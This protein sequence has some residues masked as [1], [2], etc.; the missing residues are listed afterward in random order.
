MG[1]EYKQIITSSELTKDLIGPGAIIYRADKS[2]PIN[3]FLDAL[4]WLITEA[5]RNLGIQRY[6]GLG[7]MNPEQLWE[8]TMDP[9]AR[10]L[11]QVTIEDLM[12]VEE[13][14]SKLMGDDVAPRRTFIESNAL[15]AN[16]IDI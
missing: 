13:T 16:N 10:T 6:K 8:T 4:T 3:N 5:K 11:L 15:G 14:F 7:E 1:G 12:A 2:A 9:S